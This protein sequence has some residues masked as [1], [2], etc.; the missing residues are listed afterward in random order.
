MNEN[1][2]IERTLE[3]GWRLVSMLPCE[4]LTRLSRDELQQYY[5]GSNASH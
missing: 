4:E 1:R 3:I 5:K 2:T